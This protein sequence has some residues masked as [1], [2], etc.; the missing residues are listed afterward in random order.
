MI[1]LT[2][3]AWQHGETYQ[4][5]IIEITNYNLISSLQHSNPLPI[6]LRRVFT[7]L[8]NINHEGIETRLHIRLGL[9]DVCDGHI[10]P[11]SWY[12][13]L[14]NDGRRRQGHHVNMIKIVI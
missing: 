5:Q 2:R 7:Q 3:R 8:L 1:S 14:W 12:G 6:L 4:Y 9:P 11:R 10:L 13:A